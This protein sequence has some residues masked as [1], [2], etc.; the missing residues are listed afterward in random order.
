MEEK[1]RNKKIIHTSIVGI[2]GNVALVAAKVFI[3]VLTGSSSIISDAINNLSDAMSSTVT[4]V[5]TKLSE[6]KPNKKHPYGYGRVEY[7]TATIVAAII[8]FAGGTAVYESIVSL[9]NGEK[10]VY[11]WVAFLIISLGIAAKLALGLYFRL[12]A[13]KLES[14]ALKNSGTDALFDA[15]LSAGTLVAAIVSHFAHVYLE[16]YVGILIGLFI[17]RSG[18]IAMKESLSPILGDRIDDAL[19]HEIKADICSHPGVR[20]AYDLIVHNYGEAKRIGSVHI[21]VGDELNAKEIFAL[22]REIQTYMYQKHGIFMT[23]GIYAANESDPE[24]KEIKMRLLSYVKEE[25]DVLQ[26][27]G[28]YLDKERE[29]VTFDLIVSFSAK[30]PA[31]EVV[32]GIVKKMEAD[33]PNLR[34]TC[35][36]DQDISG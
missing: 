36:I 24:A 15:L 33:F 26:C 12:R 21:E 30:C 18:V 10:P 9:I 29:M 3:G 5:G 34:F 20:G 8:L 4:I 7:L 27:H 23:V 13:K 35:N 31:E 16:G 11:D 14:A 1:T 25:P 17:I 22:E 2:V 19:A 28:F 32:D 6:K